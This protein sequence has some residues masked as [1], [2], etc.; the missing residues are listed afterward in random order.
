MARCGRLRQGR[1]RQAG[2]GRRASTSRGR[3]CCECAGPTPA[4]AKRASE[5]ACALPGRA[6]TG[7]SSP[8]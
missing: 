8:P 1:A 7:R 6:R 2:D 5:S 3:E 4:A